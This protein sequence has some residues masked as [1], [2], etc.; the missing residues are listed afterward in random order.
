[1]TGVLTHDFHNFNVYFRDNPRYQ[2]V[3]FTAEQIPGID[4][5]VYPRILA[6]SLY[7]NGIRIHPD[8]E[9]DDL[10]S[11]FNVDQVVFALSDTSHNQVMNRASQVLAAGADF[12][13]MGPNTTMLQSKKPL[14]SICAVRTGSGKSQTTRRIAE[15]LHQKKIQTV[16]IRHPMP[17]GDLTRQVCQRYATMD[18][19]DRYECTIEEREEYEPH[20]A[21]GTIVYAG[22]DY[23]QI[24]RSAEKEAD[25]ILWDGGNNDLSFYRSDLH[26]VVVDPHRPD[27]EI[28]YHPGETNLRLADV[29]IINKIET[30][31][32]D[33]IERVRK[34]IRTHAPSAIV[35]EAASPIV[36]NEFETIRGKDVLVIEDGPTLTHGGMPYGAGSIAAKKYGAKN[37]VNPRPYA[38]GSIKSIYDNYPHLGSILPAMGYGESQVHELEE[39]INNTPCDIILVGTPIDITRVVKIKKPTLRVRYELQEIGHPTLEDV[40]KS[41]IAK[42][43]KPQ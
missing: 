41:L 22:V 20:I 29:V 6:G 39:T 24:L 5:R 11:K 9:L 19:L 32:Q 15:I 8:E 43:Q 4:D 3:A 7:P 27:H 1:M 33:K 38:I 25:V 21:R 2:V 40:L 28:T 23:E 31:D 34:N 26:I 16:V 17:Y 37:M 35:I 36:V 10:I 13:L 12:R 30:A 42:I 14:I 18:D